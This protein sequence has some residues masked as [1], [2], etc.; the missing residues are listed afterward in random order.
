MNLTSSDEAHSQ[1]HLILT[2]VPRRP[3]SAPKAPRDISSRSAGHAEPPTSSLRQG[4][5]L[6]QVCATS[7][8]GMAGDWSPGCALP[9]LRGARSRRLGQVCPL[10]A[11][12]LQGGERQGIGAGLPPGSNLPQGRGREAGNWGRFASWVLPTSRGAR[13]RGLGQVCSGLGG[14]DPVRLASHALSPPRGA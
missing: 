14:P 7:R 3:H 8:G 11:T 4:R 5:G 6:G 13:G 2:E 1:C 10:G 12:Y 9:P